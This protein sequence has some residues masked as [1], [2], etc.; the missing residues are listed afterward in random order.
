MFEFRYE[1]LV[2][3]QEAVSRQLVAFCGLDWDSSCLQFHQTRRTVHTASTLQVRQPIYASS[4]GR[5]RRYRAHLG[6]LLTL[7]SPYL[8]EP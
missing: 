4:V 7:L 8:T 2:A 1:D 3:G 6:P 5:W